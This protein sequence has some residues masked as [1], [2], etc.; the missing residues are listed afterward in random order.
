LT[1]TAAV[2]ST[3]LSLGSSDTDDGTSTQWSG[4]PHL[5]DDRLVI[6][7]DLVDEPSNELCSFSGRATERRRETGRTTEQFSNLV[8]GHTGWSE[9]FEQPRR[10]GQ[11]V[12]QDANRTIFEL[13]SAERP[14]L[15][16]IRSCLGD[17]RSE[18]VVAVASAFLTACDGVSRSPRT[19]TSKPASR[20]GSAALTLH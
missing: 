20:L 2:S 5:D 13:P 6:D 16:A 8:A 4:A 1:V 17:Q 12:E 14:A 9:S 11:R 7:H 15:S 18:D 10:A 19:S 3:A